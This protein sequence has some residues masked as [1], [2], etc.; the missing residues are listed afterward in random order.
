MKNFEIGITGNPNSGKTTVFNAL[1]G[2]RQHVGNWP[3]VTVERKEGYFSKEDS[4]YTIIDL[5]GI[6]SLSAYS[7]DEIIARD[8][9]I[10][11]K[12]D[13][14]LDVLDGSNLERNLI[15]LYRYL[16]CKQMLWVY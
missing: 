16:R 3:G 14:V 6:Y 5:P 11:N 15:F 9:I 12:P 2:S 7:M 4:K 13:L 10:K 1:T 8:Y